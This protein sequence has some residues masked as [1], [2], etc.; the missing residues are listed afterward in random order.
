MSAL[1]HPDYAPSAPTYARTWQPEWPLKRLVIAAVG[2][3]VMALS[4][5]GL[6]NY[7]DTSS[8]AGADAAALGVT[9]ADAAPL[10]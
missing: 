3:V 6:A 2:C 4:G 5:G 10:N 8:A 9:Q 7:L 1:V